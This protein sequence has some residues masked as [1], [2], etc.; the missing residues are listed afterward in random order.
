MPMIV[1]RYR[2]KGICKKCGAAFLKNSANQIYC[3]ECSYW[4]RFEGGHIRDSLVLA[5]PRLK[6][7]ADESGNARVWTAR[8][9]SQ[10]FLRS[11][12]PSR[13]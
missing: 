9:C 3:P 13:Q 5:E 10:D 11:L 4:K 8:E 2:K 6:R 1:P 7:M 12:I